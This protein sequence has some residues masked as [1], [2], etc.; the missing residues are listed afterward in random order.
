[1][2]LFILK[3]YLYYVI[4][5]LFLTASMIAIFPF[6]GSGPLYPLLTEEFFLEPCLKYW[7]TNLLLISNFVPWGEFDELCGSHL[8]HVA[9]EF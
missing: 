9:N 1:M 5:V 6:I 2:L 3:S 8:T 7:W 4:P